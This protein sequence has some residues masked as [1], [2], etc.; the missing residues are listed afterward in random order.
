MKKTKVINSRIDQSMVDPTIKHITIDGTGLELRYYGDIHGDL[1]SFGR[2]IL[3]DNSIIIACGDFGVGFTT[4]KRDMAS[5]RDLNLKC[6]D[7]N[8]IVVALRGNH[9]NPDYF[10]GDY[11][12]KFS[13]VLLAPDYTILSVNDQNILCVGGNV[14]VDKERRTEGK[15]WWCGERLEYSEDKLRT[16]RNYVHEN[17]I[18]IDVIASHCSPYDG[19]PKTDF[20]INL[21]PD[22]LRYEVLEDINK[23]RSIFEFIKH[24]INNDVK[25]IFGHYH[26]HQIAK[27]YGND[28]I[29]AGMSHSITI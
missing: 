3:V 1:D 4:K 19:F 5:L 15:S 2:Y 18:T 28:I 16:I 23:M 25:V 26:T 12:N 27:L 24:E 11:L 6:K 22:W 7:H 29:S 20:D 9:D 17:N 14:S 10:N 8:V 21:L 13:N